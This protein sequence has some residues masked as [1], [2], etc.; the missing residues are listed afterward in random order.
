MLAE[1][2]TFGRKT[3][4]TLDRM[5]DPYLII[6]HDPDQER[7]YCSKCSTEF[8]GALQDAFTMFAGHRCIR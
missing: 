2:L 4:S 6:Q 3:I 1:T 8:N 7:K 5:N